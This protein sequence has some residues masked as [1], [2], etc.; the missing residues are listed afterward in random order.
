MRQHTDRLVFDFPVIQINRKN[1]HLTRQFSCISG[2]SPFECI[3][4]LLSRNSVPQLLTTR[5]CADADII[6]EQRFLWVSESV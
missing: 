5:S 4:Q 3:F 6:L 1:G 2:R